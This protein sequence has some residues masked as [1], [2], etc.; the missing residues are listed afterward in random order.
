MIA[1]S[2]YN[3]LLSAYACRPHMG[4][5]AEVGWSMA[6]ELGKYHNVWVVTRSDNRPAIEAELSTDPM[7]RL[8]FVYHNLPWT[9]WWNLGVQLHY[10]LWQLQTYF[11]ARRLH[12]RINFD[13]LHHVTY[14]KYWSP[15][16]LALLPIPLIWGPV[17]GAESTPKPFR[18]DFTRRGQVYEMLRDWG[19]W[20]GEHD[21]FVRLTAQRCVLAQATTQETA[22]RL[23]ILGAPTAQIVSEAGL[24]TKELTS[25]AK[26]TCSGQSAIRFVSI[27]R[28]LHWKGVHLGLRAF[29][30]ADLPQDAEYWIL[31]QGP[32]D[33][34]LRGLTEKLGI[35]QQVKFWGQL[36]RVE[37]LRRLG[38]C[39]ILLHP[40]LHDS[41]GWVCLEAMA[42]GRPVICLDLGG[43]ATQITKH[44]G[45]KVVA[46]TPKQCVRDLAVAMADLAASPELRS[47]LGNAGRQRVREVYNWETKGQAL[48]RLYTSILQSESQRL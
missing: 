38:E 13:L 4:S 7:P 24:D 40:S 10:Y 8:Q 26:F 39:Q 14:V 37:A 45:V 46:H 3:V 17:G 44:T 22:E 18:C 42:M 5:E 33:Q 30:Q 31:G 6:R 25:L 16:F 32:E 28:L 35:A 43:P 19:Q 12:R 41:G 15:S 36:P 29:A 47:Q 48:S 11:V 20:L 9:R 27:C 1:P 34:N 21:P 2:P 23:H